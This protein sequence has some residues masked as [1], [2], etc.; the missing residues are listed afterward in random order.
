MFEVWSL[1]KSYTSWF[2]HHLYSLHISSLWMHLFLNACGFVCC[3]YSQGTPRGHPPEVLLPHSMWWPFWKPFK[4]PAFQS[5]LSRPTAIP[6]RN[7]ESCSKSPWAT[8]GGMLLM[9]RCL[10][11]HQKDTELPA[12]LHPWQSSYPKA[13][14]TSQT[15]RCLYRPWVS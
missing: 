5:V 9:G 8:G 13:E 1:I 10:I 3:A 15:F 14:R 7:S 2:G 12:S 4:I 11:N 6:T